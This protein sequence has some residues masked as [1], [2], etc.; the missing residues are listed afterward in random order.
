M[1][2]KPEATMESKAFLVLILIL[3]IPVGGAAL[4]I[5]ISGRATN[6]STQQEEG[7]LNEMPDGS[8]GITV[9]WGGTRPIAFYDPDGDGT[10]EVPVGILGAPDQDQAWRV[11][12]EFARVYEVHV[13]NYHARSERLSWGRTVWKSVVIRYRSRPAPP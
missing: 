9:D 2:T 6:A 3:G 4:S 12:M 13:T 7:V 5:L 11:M 8:Y 1:E 10:A